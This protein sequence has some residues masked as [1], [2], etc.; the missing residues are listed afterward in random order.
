LFSSDL[1]V[2]CGLP[3]PPQDPLTEHPAY[4]QMALLASACA[5][6]WSKWNG[7]CGAEH[8]VMQV[9]SLTHSS[10]HFSFYPS[11]YV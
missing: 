4:Q 1:N 5:F 10:L 11:S 8:V 9:F 3:P 2:L 7:K 6:S